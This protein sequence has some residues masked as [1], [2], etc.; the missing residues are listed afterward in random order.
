MRSI[1]DLKEEKIRAD[2]EPLME[3]LLQSTYRYDIENEANQK[4]EAAI[5]R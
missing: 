3:T 4:V 5:F 1:Q 2:T